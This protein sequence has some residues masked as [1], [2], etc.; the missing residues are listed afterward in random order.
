M[1]RPKWTSSSGMIRDLENIRRKLESDEIDI[2]KARAITYM[3]ATAGSIY[4]TV[5]I[6]ARI[7]KL[8]DMANDKGV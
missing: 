1:A 2:N 3:I 6:E 4:K 5:E 7:N 8:E